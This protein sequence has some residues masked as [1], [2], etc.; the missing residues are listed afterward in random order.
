MKSRLTFQSTT[1]SWPTTSAM[2]AR[3]RG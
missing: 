1:N 3:A 2:R